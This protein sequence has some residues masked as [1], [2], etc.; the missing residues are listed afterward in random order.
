MQRYAV[1]SLA[2]DHHHSIFG[3]CV[4]GPGPKARFHRPCGLAVADD[5]IYVA[6]TGNHRIRV[7]DLESGKTRTLCGSGE[8]G[9]RDGAAS[10]AQFDFPTGLALSADETSLFVADEQNHRIRSIDLRTR[11]VSTVAGCGQGGTTEGPCL[12]ASFDRPCAVATVSGRSGVLLVLQRLRAGTL[13]G[14]AGETFRLRVVVC[15]SEVFSLHVATAMSSIA[16]TCDGSLLYCVARSAVCALRLPTGWMQ[17]RHH[18]HPGASAATALSCE[19]VI[20][21]RTQAAQLSRPHGLALSPSGTQLLI[22]DVERRRICVLQLMPP[23]LCGALVP[24][25]VDHV[26]VLAGNGEHRHTNG[27]GGSASFN[28]PMA[29]AAARRNG[30]LVVI[31]EHALRMIADRELVLKVKL[32]EKAVHSQLARDVLAMIPAAY[33]LHGL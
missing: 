29:I 14:A 15:G 9:H 3:E 23:A 7:V 31:D 25:E 22:C 16:P 20:E 1:R 10:R 19:I 24:R 2:G 5:C 28:V 30:G 18:R 26:E 32:L 6:D 8:A 17:R 11:V 33:A 27:P 12:E 13:P 21:A 4:N